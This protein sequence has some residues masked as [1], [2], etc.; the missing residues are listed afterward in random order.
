MAFSLFGKKDEPRT[1]KKTT[2]GAVK[3]PGDQ[4]HEPAPSPKSA[5]RQ[6]AA[7]TPGGGDLSLDFSHYAPP[8]PKARSTPH[9]LPRQPAAPAQTAAAAPPP[10]K[11][12][13]AAPA[14]QAPTRK[15]EAVAPALR[16]YTLSPGALAAS[17]PPP[18][19]TPA[20]AAA[21][22][23]PKPSGVLAAAATSGAPAE[24]KPPATTRGTVTTT[25]ATQE[26]WPPVSESSVQ[27]P[28]PDSIMNIE[29]TG[30]AADTAPVIE[31]AAILFANG[32]SL[33]ALT[34]LT[35]A[36][37]NGNLGPSALQ[38]WL[39]LFDL[40]RSLSMRAEFEALGMEFLAEFERSPPVWIE[41]EPQFD[42]ALAT[43]G[44]GYCALTG[45]LSDESASQ[46][47]QLRRMSQQ[48]QAI[49]I[50]FAKLEGV[51]PF[52]CA[53]LLAMLEVLKTSGKEVIF[54]GE[55]HLLRLL[56]AECQTQNKDTDGM[57]WSLLFE[58]LRRLGLKDRFEEAAVNYAVTYELSP[59]SWE[60][61][62]G[63]KPRLSPYA[64]AT[65]CEQPAFQLSGDVTGANESLPK[66]LQD[67]AKSNSPV[68]IDMSAV[69][70]VDFVSAGQLLN[71][72]TKLHQAGAT[73]QIRGA[74]ELV[75]ALFG[76]MGIQQVARIIRNR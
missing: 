7:P 71:V 25:P 36:V 59:P 18:A 33:Q 72:F 42:P 58:I 67:W 22:P 45:M 20:P 57:L 32:Q 51:D 62:T 16:A 64:A 27:E 39:M 37:H 29:V 41:A 47:E 11:Q 73:I 50:D 46:L 8:P 55:A 56:Q 17:P 6:E 61:H 28:P 48:R 68:V 9:G 54:T 23:V 13:A 65:D 70:R 24:A 66:K 12:E 21:S 3:K 5:G 43:G 34:A 31:E 26:T 49:R 69:R 63:A 30:S 35:K 74:N 38:T 2:T 44:I 14:P 15:P 60:T 19:L 53:R 40:Y 4:A 52:G 10:Q 75:A 1:K 76:V